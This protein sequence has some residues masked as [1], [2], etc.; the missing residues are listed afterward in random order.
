MSYINY[1]D[2]MRARNENLRAYHLKHPKITQ[3]RLARIFKISQSRVSR[4][5][6]RAENKGG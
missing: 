6:G 3:I 4:I 2:K 5:L 1:L